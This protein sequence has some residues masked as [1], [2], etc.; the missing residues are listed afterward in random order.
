MPVEKPRLARSGNLGDP[1]AEGLPQFVAAVSP[2][3]IWVL[4]PI[5]KRSTDVDLQQSTSN[6]GTKARTRVVVYNN[7]PYNNALHQTGRGGVAFRP[8]RPVVEAR[9]AGERECCAGL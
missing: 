6:Y 7:R 9:P 2:R 8:S 5:G 1:I 4:P 3:R